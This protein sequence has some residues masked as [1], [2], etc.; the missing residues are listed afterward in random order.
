MPHNAI[1]TADLVTVRCPLCREVIPE[2]GTG[3]LVW[4]IG[5][6]HRQARRGA[7][8]CECGA[9]VQIGNQPVRMVRPD[10]RT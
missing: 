1:L 6:L 3:L 7:L 5:D 8:E 4:E 10:T 9:Y 2:P